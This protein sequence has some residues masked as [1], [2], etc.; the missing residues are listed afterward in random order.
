MALANFQTAVTDA[1]VIIYIDN[2]GVVGALLAGA[3]A[4]PDANMLNADFW[5]RAAQH[6][7]AI[8]LWRVESKANVADAPSR[9]SF[10]ELRDWDAVEVRPILPP[11]VHQLWHDLVTPF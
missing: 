10:D 5:L 3:G 11:V 6:N 8:Q 7:I 1:A 2:D 4:A 9:G